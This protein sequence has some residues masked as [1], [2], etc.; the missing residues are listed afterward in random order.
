VERN[1]NFNLSKQVQTI[2]AFM[3]MA[4]MAWTG[5]TIIVLETDTA[6]I[7]VKM[8][9]LID[10]VKEVVPREENEKRW[11]SL[12]RRQDAAESRISRDEQFI[13]SNASNKAG[14]QK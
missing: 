9:F 10:K 3:V 11:E 5:W 13:Y 4:L 1:D 6:K 7:N 12:E 14:T 8:D 2:I